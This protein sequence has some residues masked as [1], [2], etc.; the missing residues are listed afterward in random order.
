MH[1]E[2]NDPALSRA[3]EAAEGLQNEFQSR[4][5]RPITFFT[6]GLRDLALGTSHVMRHI[7]NRPDFFDGEAG[8]LP[9][10]QHNQRDKHADG[11][12]QLEDLEY[13]R[14]TAMAL[15]SRIVQM[16]SHSNATY[17]SRDKLGK[18]YWN[19]PMTELWR[20]FPQ[21]MACVERLAELIGDYA[22]LLMKPAPNKALSDYAVETRLWELRE[23]ARQERRDNGAQSALR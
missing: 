6:Q 22:P 18:I 2:P 12:L 19:D 11:E 8:H 14:R 10:R 4:T 21:E 7:A 9:H 17:Y 13:M 23:K 20:H 3:L 15:R 16:G 1:L 5:R